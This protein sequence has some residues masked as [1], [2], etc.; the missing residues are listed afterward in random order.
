MFGDQRL[1]EKFWEKVIP[2]DTGCWHWVGGASSGYGTLW[3]PGGKGSRN[4]YAHRIAY[5][6]LVGP[7][8]EETIDHV[9]RNRACVNPAHLE[10]ASVRENTLR[11]MGPTAQNAR[12]S[13]CKRGHLLSGDNLKESASKRR[14]NRECRICYKQVERAYRENNRDEINARKRARR[15][16]LKIARAALPEGE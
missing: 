7:I 8:I 9:C 11:G 4:A 12:K 6:V 3:H 2:C 13:H 1:P 14:G 10:P 5:E 16:A 15:A